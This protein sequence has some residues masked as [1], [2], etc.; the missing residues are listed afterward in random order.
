MMAYMQ[1]LKKQKT[2]ARKNGQL[3]EKEANPITF[4]LYRLICFYALSSGDIFTWAHTVCQWN[5]MAR[6]VNIDGF[7]FP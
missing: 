3:E 4:S 1:S 2:T 6:S 7:S 5:C